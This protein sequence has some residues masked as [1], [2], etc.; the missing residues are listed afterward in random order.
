[1]ANDVE[2]FFRTRKAPEVRRAVQQSIEKIR[3]NAAWRKRNG[4][5]LAG[6]FTD[7]RM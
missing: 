5:D 6:W 2:R 1:M 3:V 4:K 7:H